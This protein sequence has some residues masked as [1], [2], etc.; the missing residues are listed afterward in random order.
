MVRQKIDERGLVM[1]D[2]TLG[3]LVSVCPREH[4]PQIGSPLLSGEGGGAWGHSRGSQEKVY[5]RSPGRK[6]LVSTCYCLGSGSS[7]GY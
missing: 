1:I 7:A 2:A 6:D 4:M 3:I 5:G